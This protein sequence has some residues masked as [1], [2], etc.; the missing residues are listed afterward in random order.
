VVRGV[1]GA[2]AGRVVRAS[3]PG[4]AQ[5]V[6]GD[7]VRPGSARDRDTAIAREHAIPRQARGPGTLE[8]EPDGDPAERV[9]ADPD[10]PRLRAHQDV[11]GV[12]E[13]QAERHAPDE[14]APDLDGTVAGRGA[15]VEARKDDHPVLERG[16]CLRRAERT[17]DDVAADRAR[18]STQEPD[19]ERAHR[20]D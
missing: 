8:V 19:A 18:R 15:R 20:P 9:A 11:A 14:I 3:A 13:P 5:D 1:G 7:A 12:R 2:G 10:V 4:A 16:P 6:A 17:L